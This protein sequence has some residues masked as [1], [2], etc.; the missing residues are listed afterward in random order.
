MSDSTPEYEELQK[1]IQKLRSRVSDLE[2]LNLDLSPIFPTVESAK[3]VRVL[4]RKPLLVEVPVHVIANPENC[5]TVIN[6]TVRGLGV[7]GIRCSVREPLR[8]KICPPDNLNL[9]SFSLEAV[10]RWTQQE[11]DTGDSYCGLEIS[12]IASPDMSNLCALLMVLGHEYLRDQFRRKKSEEALNIIDSSSDLI[13]RFTQDS[14][15]TFVNNA[16]CKYSSLSRE[17]LTG[18]QFDSFIPEYFREG[19]REFLKTYS[20]ADHTGSYECPLL[21][22]SSESR[23]FNWTVDIR[24]SSEDEQL[25]FQFIGRDITEPKRI[26]QELRDSNIE[27]EARIKERTKQ[28]EQ[29]NVKLSEEIKLRKRVEEALDRRLWALTRPDLNIGA[30]DLTEIMDI[31]VLQEIQES[32]S[33]FWNISVELIG[34]TGRQITAPR[35]VSDFYAT[36][37]STEDGRRL[38]EKKNLG[39]ISKTGT[40]TIFSL[41]NFLLTGDTCYVIPISIRGHHVGAWKIG[42]SFENEPDPGEVERL[43]QDI[44]VDPSALFRSLASSPKKCG[45]RLQDV[46]NFLRLISGQV[47]MLG[48]QN[49]SQA[50]MI[51]ELKIAQSAIQNSEEKLKNLFESAPIGI[52]I[53]NQGVISYA[54][55]CLAQMYGFS[56]NEEIEGLSLGGLFIDGEQDHGLSESNSTQN[57]CSKE[58]SSLKAI[59]KDDQVFDVSLYCSRLSQESESEL[60]AFV[61]DKSQEIAL[62]NQLL[63][64][65]KMEALGT[66]AGGVAHDFNNVLT[67]IMGNAEIALTETTRNQDV[68]LQLELILEASGRARDLVSQILTFCRKGEQ[69]KKPLNIVPLIKE[70]VKFLDASLPATINVQSKIQA[71]DSMIMGDP[72]QIHQVLMNLC[73]NAGYAMR[74]KGGVL[75]ICL[76]LSEIIQPEPMGNPMLKPGDY[77]KLTVRDTGP[78]IDPEI[79]DRIFEPYFTTKAPGEGSGL[80][81]AV[82]HGIVVS[83]S[84]LIR[85]D[86]TYD[87]GASFEIF[88]PIIESADTLNDEEADTNLS[89]DQRIMVV[90]DEKVVCEIA[91]ETLES[92]GYKVV[93][94]VNPVVALNIFRISPYDFDLVITDLTMNEMTGVALA[95]EIKKI[96]PEIPVILSTGY[97][98]DHE[99]SDE[100]VT[101]VN[102]TLQ[103]PFTKRIL[104]KAVKA[105]IQGS[106]TNSKPWRLSKD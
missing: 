106:Q 12:G 77:L 105:A 44:G 32:V 25:E 103:K 53:A 40:E 71:P 79:R 21:T 22:A 69:Q 62:R 39:I 98:A 60:L 48:L 85:I 27:L 43:A 104:A 14:V 101:T 30:I 100:D 49:L 81:L 26:E 3:Q 99:L 73:S 31:R 1:E 35:R 72:V 5:G 29:I 84:G 52:F 90:D 95:Q 4:D 38:A 34:T 86:E 6:M 67:I 57:V 50:R 78:G 8:L 54:N 18:L 28:L 96:R 63:H 11:D 102:Q 16:F 58:Y 97:D 45:K 47:S 68:S 88:F 37:Y 36:V 59:R 9:A 56:S 93:T 66:L 24:S 87:H 94:F 55:H 20:C 61:I 42:Q 65:Q 75:E 23:I 89:G 64:A 80:G 15:I 33:D 7:R 10:C 70:T 82:V 41:Q 51:N 91:R 83:H 74:R 76:E 19:F 46:A 13:V 2:T 17:N 92:H